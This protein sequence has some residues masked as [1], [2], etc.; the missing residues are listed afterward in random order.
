M[1]NTNPCYT[2][3]SH[4]K[5]FIHTIIGAE[6]SIICYLP[7]VYTEKALGVILRI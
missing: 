6:T 7:A 4:H 3:I 5:K 1:E 2:N